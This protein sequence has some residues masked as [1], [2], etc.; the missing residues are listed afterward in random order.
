MLQKLPIKKKKKNIIVKE[1]QNKK[2]KYLGQCPQ[3]TLLENA[4]SPLPPIGLT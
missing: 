2:R 4:A 3:K 1:R